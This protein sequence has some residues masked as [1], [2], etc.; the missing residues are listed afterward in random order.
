VYHDAVG[1]RVALHFP[2]TTRAAQAR[3][4][5]ARIEALHP[6][7]DVNE[8]RI[9]Y[10]LDVGGEDTS[11]HGA[12]DRASFNLFCQALGIDDANAELYWFYVVAARASN[13]AY[14]RVLSAWYAE[15]IFQPE[16][17]QVYRSISAEELRYLRAEAE[18][19]VYRVVRVIPPDPR[20]EERT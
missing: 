12:R 3:A 5:R 13:Q 14:G 2:Q 15:I 18:T 6:G 19:C 17:A 11:P 20:A 8:N 1:R 4:I 7:A 9:R 16:T 10:W